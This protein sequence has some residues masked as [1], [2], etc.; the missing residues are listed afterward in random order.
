MIYK[1]HADSDKSTLRP[2]AKAA[3][4]SAMQDMHIQQ[5]NVGKLRSR[6]NL[7]K[8]YYSIF[9]LYLVAI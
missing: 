3:A 5:C 2:G 6:H 9:M 8:V 7:S 4:A 1:H